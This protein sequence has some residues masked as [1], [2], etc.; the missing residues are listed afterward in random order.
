M[1]ARAIKKKFVRTENIGW[2]AEY[3]EVYVSVRSGKGVLTPGKTLEELQAEG[4]H[5][6][7]HE[8]H[9]KPIYELPFYWAKDISYI[10]EWSGRD[11]WVLKEKVIW[12][13]WKN[14]CS[15]IRTAS[16]SLGTEA[17]LRVHRNPPVG[18]SRGLHVHGR[19]ELEKRGY[20]GSHY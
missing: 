1:N 14:L 15:E 5:E 16:S 7:W 10:G 12:G 2:G 8:R 19:K 17:D 3:R 4:V 9:M 13:Y 6:R 11:W 18:W 20:R